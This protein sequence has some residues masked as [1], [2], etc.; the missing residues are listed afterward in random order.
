MHVEAEKQKR[1][2]LG[3][4]SSSGGGGGFLA[5]ASIGARCFQISSSSSLR[6]YPRKEKKWALEKCLMRARFA[7][8]IR[9][10]RGP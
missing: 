8:F 1:D 4:I 9:G 5:E 10:S 6:G 3:A 2:P 7:Y